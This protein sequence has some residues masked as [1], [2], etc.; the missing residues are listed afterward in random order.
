[1]PAANSWGEETWAGFRFPRLGTRR[2]R[3]WEKEK[4]P[5][6]IK[7]VWEKEPPWKKSMQEGG[8]LPCKRAKRTWPRGLLHW[9]KNSQDGT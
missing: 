6:I 4:P 8:E 9:V 7:N 1:M 3:K 5:C 2:R